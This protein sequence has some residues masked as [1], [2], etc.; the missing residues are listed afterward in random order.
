MSANEIRIPKQKRSIEKRT[1]II[2]A[3]YDLFCEK[4]YYRTN[5]AEIAKAAGVSTGIV[6]SYFHDKKDILK[7]VVG[8]YIFRLEEQFR[9]IFCSTI[10][11]GNIALV[12]EKF[13]DLSIASHTMNAA[14]HNEFLA[15]A[16]LNNDIQ[17]LFN[18]FESKMLEIL[19]EKLVAAGYLGDL[20]LERL[21]ICYGIIEQL[22]HEHIRYKR[23]D[24]ELSNMK[25]IAISTIVGLLDM[26]T[27]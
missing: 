22:C 11:R 16:L 6:Y 1:A 18:H 10:D 2:N 20:L 14:A 12:I 27:G 5:T 19:Y 26:A 4:G 23:N 15:L 21:R 13:I 9:P 7:E 25:S 17:V 3:S 8:L 24:V